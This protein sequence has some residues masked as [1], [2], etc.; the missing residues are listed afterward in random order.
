MI[1]LKS[2]SWVSALLLLTSVAAVLIGMV[3]GQEKTEKPVLHGK[4]W[5]A[6]TGKPMAATAGSMMY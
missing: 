5:I 2:I 3:F 6:I 4:H 1:S